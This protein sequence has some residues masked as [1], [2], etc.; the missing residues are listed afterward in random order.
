MVLIDTAWTPEAT[1]ALLGR[2][3]KEQGLVGGMAILTHAHDDRMGG[4]DVA[5]AQ[6][7]MTWAASATK[8]DARRRGLGE[9]QVSI[10]A[11]HQVF[12]LPGATLDV[13]HPGPGHTRDNVVVYHRESG[14]LFGG[15]LVRAA[16]AAG[17]GN[18]ADADIDAWASSIAKLQEAFPDAR[19]VVP[20]H[21]APGGPE[22]LEHTK[23]LAEAAANDS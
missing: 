14:V 4:L 22:L 8:R 15:C 16:N 3:K 9:P 20:G 21:G 18:T 19:I 5:H 6:G 2:L 10:R 23:A 11:D 1:E 13:F 7:F 17:L 12:T